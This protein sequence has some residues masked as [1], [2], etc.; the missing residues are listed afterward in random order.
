MRK[1]PLRELVLTTLLGLGATQLSGCVPVVAVGAGT[2]ILMAED[3]RT[4]GTYLM[5]EE[6]ELKAGSRIRDAFGKEVHVN[7]TS[8]NRRVLLTGEVPNNEVRAKVKELVMG[9]PNV[10]E[11]QNELVIGGVST[12]G[13]RSNDTYLTA[14]VKTRLFDDKRFNAN[15]VKVVTEAGTTFLMGIVKREEGD[16]AAEVAAKTKGVTKVVKVFEYMD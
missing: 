15:H 6:I 1:F 8:F 14:K 16:A 10:K 3:R 12:F 5:D 7:V 13:A 9:V 2:G 11:V 4:A